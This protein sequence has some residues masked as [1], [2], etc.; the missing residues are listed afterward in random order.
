VA[1]AGDG[2]GGGG[3]GGG[4]GGAAVTAGAT[5][6]PASQMRSP[7]QSVSFEHPACATHND[8]NTESTIATSHTL[9]HQRPTHALSPGVL[10]PK[11]TAERHLPADRPRAP[12]V[13]V[14]EAV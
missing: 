10:T 12:G 9:G 8:T 4:G 3:G 11:V 14:F 1:G 7:L 6:R 13:L 2:A 5:Q